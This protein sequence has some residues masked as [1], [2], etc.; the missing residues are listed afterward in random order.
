MPSCSTTRRR[1]PRQPP[2]RPTLPTTFDVIIQ[3]PS[4]PS[5]PVFG[6]LST[7]PAP[8][9]SQ[10]DPGSAPGAPTI[11]PRW[12]DAATATALGRELAAWPSHVLTADQAATLIR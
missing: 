7:A 4:R 6:P 5:G 8:M 3:A 1:R 10:T 12:A 2:G 9:S 11:Q